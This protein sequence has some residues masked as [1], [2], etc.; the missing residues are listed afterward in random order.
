MQLNKGKM[1]NKGMAPIMV[2][3][4]VLLFLVVG[5]FGYTT[6][7]FGWGPQSGNLAAKQDPNA[8][9]T[10]PVAV[11]GA[12]DTLTA[13]FLAVNKYD[14]TEPIAGTHQYRTR[15]SGEDWSSYQAVT[16]GASATIRS[17]GQLEVVSGIGNASNGVF[18]HRKIYDL[19][20]EGA[21]TFTDKEIVKNSTFTIVIK[22]DDDGL[23]NAAGTN[24]TIGASQEA[25]MEATIAA[26]GEKGAPYGV[27]LIYEYS[28]NYDV[29]G[30]NLVGPVITGTMETPDWYTVSAVGS[31]TKTYKTSPLLGSSKQDFQECFKTGSGDN[32]TAGTDDLRITVAPISLVLNSETGEYEFGIQ[33]K[34]GNAIDPAPSAAKVTYVD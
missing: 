7:W 12:A 33:D 17:V 24:Q 11:S 18:A 6:N 28:S 16:N 9:Y 3:V 25:C 14:S 26:T 29:G 2:V 4:L 34:D 27:A 21:R 32:P 31:K 5:L 10:G 22:N 30:M 8:A 13:T 15:G 23:T 19:T 20:G 1:G